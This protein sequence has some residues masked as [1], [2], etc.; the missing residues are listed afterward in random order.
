M[1]S[2][3]AAPSSA[4]L[5]NGAA[6][7]PISHLLEGVAGPQN[8]RFVH[9]ASNNLESNRK[10]IGGFAP[11]QCQ[12]W[13]PAHI[14]RRS[15]AKARHSFGRCTAS[16]ISQGWRGAVHRGHDEQVD[17]AEEGIELA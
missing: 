3:G 9:M 17:I 4:L 11:G 8:Q 5:I 1:I 13:M 16:D 6:S 14:K 12:R 7:M 15:E 2:G 10:A